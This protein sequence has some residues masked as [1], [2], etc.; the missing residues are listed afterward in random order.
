[1]LMDFDGKTALK[2]IFERYQFPDRYFDDFIID[3]L[4]DADKTYD[5]NNIPDLNFPTDLKT[6]LFKK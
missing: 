6:M 5:L 2:N 3:T 4:E 1:M